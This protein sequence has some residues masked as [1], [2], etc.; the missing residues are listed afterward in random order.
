MP[1][2]SSSHF[3]FNNKHPVYLAARD[4]AFARSGGLS[5]CAASNPPS[6]HTTGPSTIRRPTRRAPTT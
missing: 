1:D 4:E 3:K 2:D 6:R 5:S